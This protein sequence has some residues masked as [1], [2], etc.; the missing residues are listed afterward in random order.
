MLSAETKQAV[1]ELYFNM[2]K[3][4]IKGYKKNF[5]K[6]RNKPFKLSD[7]Q[8]KILNQ[9]LKQTN[10]VLKILQTQSHFKVNKLMLKQ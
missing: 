4:D 2:A 3:E 1:K 5:Y 8:Y 7:K 9:G 10:K 6:Y